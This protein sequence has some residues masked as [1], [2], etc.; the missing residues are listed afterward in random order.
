VK[1]FLQS[2][3]GADAAREDGGDK[4][5]V[6][7]V[8]GMSFWADMQLPSESDVVQARAR[9]SL[10]GSPNPEDVALDR[11]GTGQ[12]MGLLGIPIS[13]LYEGAKPI[14]AASPAVNNLVGQL[15]GPEQMVDETTQRPTSTQALGNVGATALGALSNYRKFLGGW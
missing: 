14:M 15:F 10:G 8:N 7:G 3:L 13:A 1:R 6:Q 11:Y 2:G 12:E 9:R 5:A 4:L